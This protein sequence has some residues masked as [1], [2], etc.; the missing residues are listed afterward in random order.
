MKAWK[1]TLSVGVYF[2]WIPDPSLF[3][4][5][6]QYANTTTLYCAQ[7]DTAGISRGCALF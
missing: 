2:S 7:P 5:N 3:L 4:L 6:T 1:N